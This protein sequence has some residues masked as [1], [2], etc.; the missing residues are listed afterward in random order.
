MKHDTDT[1]EHARY[2][3]IL[4][5]DYYSLFKF[6]KLDERFI[7]GEWVYIHLC[8]WTGTASGR[9]HKR[10]GDKDSGFSDAHRTH[11]EQTSHHK[12]STLHDRSKTPHAPRIEKQ[13]KLITS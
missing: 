12:H 4:I 6:T 3:L 10:S 7:K 11:L 5:L 1:F 8:F 13:S 9:T 2:I